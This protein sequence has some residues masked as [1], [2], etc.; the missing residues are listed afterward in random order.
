[1]TLLVNDILNYLQTAGGDAPA[2]VAKC[3]QQYS[4]KLDKQLLDFLTEIIKKH[5]P[6]L[7]FNAYWSLKHVEV[8]MLR[9]QAQQDPKLFNICFS[10]EDLSNIKGS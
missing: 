2:L 1:M 4:I 6:T 3:M 8:L 10:D 5:L 7:A 9:L